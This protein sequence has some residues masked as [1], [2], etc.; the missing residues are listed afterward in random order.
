[1]RDRDVRK[2]KENESLDDKNAQLV[3][4]VKDHYAKVYELAE[5]R[6]R[7]QKNIPVIGMGHLF[8]AGEKRL[9]AMG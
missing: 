3:S 8:A 9:K 2:T 5:K 7:Q 1:M 6:K 4:G